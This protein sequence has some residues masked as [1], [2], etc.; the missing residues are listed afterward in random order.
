MVIL[1]GLLGLIHFRLVASLIQ[2]EV[3][4]P[5]LDIGCMVLHRFG[6]RGNL[7]YLWSFGL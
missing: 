3:V 2:L 5:F 6:T 7:S 4:G 1:F